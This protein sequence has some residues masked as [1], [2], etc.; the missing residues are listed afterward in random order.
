MVTKKQFFANF[1]A[2]T[3][4]IGA[5]FGRSLVVLGIHIPSK[6]QASAP[7]DSCASWAE[8]LVA[9]A[10]FSHQN[11]GKR[12][13]LSILLINRLSNLTLNRASAAVHRHRRLPLGRN[14][15]SW[16]YQR[17]AKFYSNRF[18]GCREIGE[19]LLFFVTILKGGKNAEIDKTFQWIS[20]PKHGIHPWCY[21]Y[22]KCS[23]CGEYESVVAFLKQAIAEKLIFFC[24]F[25]NLKKKWENQAKYRLG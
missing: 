5:K 23:W 2:T 21:I 18:S 17:S 10:I 19:K 7:T 13:F 15:H 20:H 25:C 22:L 8:S 24:N 4:P 12:L 9:Q 3:E 16:D 1:P 11:G 6:R 14:V